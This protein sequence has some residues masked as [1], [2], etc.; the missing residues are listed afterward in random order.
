N[1]GHV[2]FSGTIYNYAQ[3]V[4]AAVMLE[5]ESGM[6]TVLRDNQTV[7]GINGYRISSTVY[8]KLNDQDDI[9]FSQFRASELD[10]TDRAGIF[11]I[12]DGDPGDLSRISHQLPDGT[13]G[14]KRLRAEDFT[15]DG[16]VITTGTIGS[17]PTPQGS[18][19]L[20]A[21]YRA[22]DLLKEVIRQGQLAPNTT[23]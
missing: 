4:R 20:D 12:H 23:N 17:Y 6:H 5:D 14:P 2:A 9:A 10:P 22:N 7:P 16:F 11:V 18:R 15:N 8:F 19:S 3:D 21:L 13:T 1:S